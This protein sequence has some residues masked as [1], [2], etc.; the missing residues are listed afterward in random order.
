MFDAYGTLFDIHSAVRRE[1][2]RLGERA[3]AL[4]DLWRSKQLEYSWVRSLLGAP[5]DFWACTTAA[6][7]F[8][9]QAGGVAEPG[10]RQALL[11][12]YR[13]VDA[14]DDAAPLLKR[15]RARGRK[16]AILS[17][18]TPKMLADAVGSA[19]L[20]PLFDA[21]LSVEPAGVFKPDRRVY[22]CVAARFAVTAGE[23]AF[24]SA[25]AWDIAGAQAFGFRTIWI[26][27]TGKPAEYGIEHAARVARSLGE[28]AEL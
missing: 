19:G 5:A 12:A 8:A 24:C 3:A 17:N 22:A 21:M 27:R 15:L 23:V 13:K 9:L 26:N 10:L 20:G 25:N 6:L 18:G 28:L 4:S 2:G 1:A 16:T 11:D 14:F 7:D